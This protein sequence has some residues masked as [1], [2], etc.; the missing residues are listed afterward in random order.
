M[1]LRQIQKEGRLNM[2]LDTSHNCWHGS[3]SAFMRWR[4]K[5]A[6]VAGLPP[7][8]LMEGFFDNRSFLVVDSLLKDRLP[9]KWECLKPSPLHTLLRHSDCDG[10][11]PWRDCKGIAE[12]LQV[13]L[14]LLPQEPAWGH[15]GDWRQKT[16]TFI[17]GL[18]CA[19][20][21]K[22]NVDFH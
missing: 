20:E 11:I 6:E 17:D 22:E 18:L 13:L 2:G 14:P 7:L 15:I 21:S 5:I 4:S 10:K 3:Y 1:A 19:Y 16:Q 9:I 8:D 12:A